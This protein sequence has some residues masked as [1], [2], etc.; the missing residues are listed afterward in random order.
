MPEL[1]TLQPRVGNLQIFQPREMPE[2]IPDTRAASKESGKAALY[3]ALGTALSELPKKLIEAYEEGRK[4]R[5]RGQLD[6]Q[7]QS[8][9]QNPSSGELS[10]FTVTPSGI[11]YN[12]Q[13][14][15]MRR[16]QIAALT[17]RG[18]TEYDRA[19]EQVRG[20]AAAPIV[21]PTQTQEQMPQQNQ[22][23]DFSAPLM[24]DVNPDEILPPVDFEPAGKDA[25]KLALA[26]M[27]AQPQPG[28]EEL[29]DGTIVQTLPGGKKRAI[30]PTDKNTWVD[31]TPESTGKRETQIVPQ[32]QPDGS[33]LNVLV[34]RNT[35]DVIKEINTRPTSRS[36]TQKP[37][38][39]I[40]Q[41]VTDGINA[42]QGLEDVL[43]E[44]ERMPDIGMAEKAALLKQAKPSSGMLD[45]LV[46]QGA[47]SMVSDDALQLETLRNRVNSMIIFAK[48]GS[49]LTES[50]KQ[51]LTIVEPDDSKEAAIIK[52]KTA[53]PI[54]RKELQTYAKQYPGSFP[55]LDAMS[56]TTAPIPGTE[57]SLAAKPA[58][59]SATLT[60]SDQEAIKWL[61]ANPNHPKAATIKAML[62]AK[63][64]SF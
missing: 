4:L 6:Q 8:A 44:R 5:I 23:A 43:R 22:L 42:I 35:G 30:T 21:I 11:T 1:A 39:T 26:E 27:Q 19:L 61:A 57:E 59:Q 52:I 28:V 29:T 56:G 63:G 45:S 12:P 40:S 64:A 18:Q 49:A 53:I 38:A 32:Q 48:G 54:L 31:I 15:E 46:R 62:K 33:V 2:L 7:Y 14:A 9:L 51:A 60:A 34:D 47:Q 13:D 37:T 55:A 58:A 17:N 3:G 10:N 16:L 41:R 36:N 24:H 25:S 20:G 50:E